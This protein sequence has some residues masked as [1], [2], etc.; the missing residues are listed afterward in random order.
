MESPKGEEE[1]FITYVSLYIYTLSPQKHKFYVS[2]FCYWYINLRE[3]LQAHF[4]FTV[5]LYIV[6]FN[7]FFLSS[8]QRTRVSF[9]FFFLLRCCSLYLSCDNSQLNKN[10]AL[11]INY[12]TDTN[13]LGSSV[14]SAACA[15]VWYFLRVSN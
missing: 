1:G 2:L 11:Y 13:E 7:A 9:Y 15:D 12:M 3:L 4:V 6:K 5:W 14:N 10:L 8:F